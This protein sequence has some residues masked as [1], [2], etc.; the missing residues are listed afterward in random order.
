M[1]GR[2]A[3]GPGSIPNDTDFR[4]RRAL[5]EILYLLALLGLY[6]FSLCWPLA[7]LVIG[8]TL[9][10]GGTADETRKAGRICLI[11]G[12]LNL[13][14]TLLLLATLA[15]VGDALPRMPFLYREGL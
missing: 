5:L 13:I 9:L 15:A 6:W 11:L 10:V 7:G 4:R 14:L 3:P 12:I 2:N 8:I 1:D